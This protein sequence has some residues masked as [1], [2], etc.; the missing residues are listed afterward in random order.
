MIYDN[1]Y[2]QINLKKNSYIYLKFYYDYI[3]LSI[4]NK[5]LFNQRIESF[6]ILKKIENLTYHLKLSFVMKIYFIMFVVQLKSVSLN[7]NFY[8]RLK[9]K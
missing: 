9:F 2:I 6:K 4:I 7:E 8:Q 1:K 5:K 3:I